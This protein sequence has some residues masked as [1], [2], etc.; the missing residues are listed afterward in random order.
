MAETPYIVF[1]AVFD[2]AAVGDE[3]RPFFFEDLP[4]RLLG[5]LG[6]G[7]RLRP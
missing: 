7:M 5:P 2:A 4:D 3:L 1:D 6:M